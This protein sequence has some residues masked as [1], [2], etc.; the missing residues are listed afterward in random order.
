M[1]FGEIGEKINATIT[2]AISIERRALRKL[3]GPSRIIREYFEVGM[4][5]L[6]PVPNW[7]W[8]N[9]MHEYSSI[10]EATKI[11]NDDK[12]DDLG[13]LPIQKNIK[14]KRMPD[15]KS[16]IYD[17]RSC[18]IL[19]LEKKS[20]LRKMGYST[21][22]EERERQRILEVAVRWHGKQKVYDLLYFFVLFHQNDYK[23]DRAV[24]IWEKDLN[25]VVCMK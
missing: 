4:D 10:E 7:V 13:V 3:R 6:K 11:S 19:N 1:T 25:Y 20:F 23:M 24:E 8:S 5:T 16:N 9:T 2:D 22:V 14:M 15:G 18:D 21:F 17:E 12:D